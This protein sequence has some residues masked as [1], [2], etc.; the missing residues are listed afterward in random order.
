M[1]TRRR[2]SRLLAVVL[3]LC[4]AC[5]PA[6]QA[7]LRVGTVP[8]PGYEP[9]FLAREL[10]LFPAQRVHL[11]EYV[12]SAQSVRAFRNGAIDAIAASLEEALL[13]DELGHEPRVV[14][15]FDASHGADCLM[16]R[17]EV[18]G[19]S[20]LKG[21]R[22]GSED[23]MLGLYMLNRALQ[24]TGLR[25]EDV[26]LEFSPLETHVEAYQR[27]E[28]DAVVTY[29]PYCQQLADVGARRLFDSKNIPGEVVDVLVVRQS[30]LEAHPEQ[31]DALLRGWFA[32]LAWTREHPQEGVRRMARRLD[33]DAGRFQETLSG[34][35][36][37]GEHEQH[38]QL[39]GPRPRLYDSIERLGE[40]LRHHQLLRKQPE[41]SRL[42][43]DG[44]LLR[45]SP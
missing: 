26:R 24:E 23:S 8:W 25:R 42:L 29:E 20:A 11:V 30:V 32:A 28:L 36:L 45:V 27:G 33:L 34:L 16:T 6:P 21:R 41:A 37:M 9:L 43:D 17:P 18:A 3:L 31:V 5:T 38:A 2:Q 22:V 44:P 4:A 1:N 10:G 13:F 35:Q 19:L 12:T 7:P 39:T 14:L 40:L 15:V